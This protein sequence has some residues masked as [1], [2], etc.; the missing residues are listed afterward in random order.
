MSLEYELITNRSY[1]KTIYETFDENDNSLY[2]KSVNN[3]EYLFFSNRVAIDEY[4]FYNFTKN[5]KKTKFLLNFK[6]YYLVLL[7]FGILKMI[8]TD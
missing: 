7:K 3:N 5:L 2:I 6:W 1:V 8:I 4:I